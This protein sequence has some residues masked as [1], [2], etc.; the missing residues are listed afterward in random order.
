MLSCFV[1]RANVQMPILLPLRKGELSEWL[2]NQDAAIRQWVKIVKFSAK[3]GEVQ[4]IPASGEKAGLALVGLGDGEDVLAFGAAVS[5]L[6]EGEYRLHPDIAHPEPYLL[7]FGMGAYRFDQYKSK[8]KNLAKLAWPSMELEKQLTPLLESIYLARDMIN[9]PAEDMGPE[10]IAKQVV[11]IAKANQAKINII[12]GQDLLKKNY[13]SIHAVGRASS[14]PPLLID[15]RWGHSGPQIVLVGKGVCFDSG[16]LDIKG[17]S[18]MQMMKKDMGGAALM[19]ALAQAIMKRKLKLRL[20]LLIPAVDNAISGNA[21][22]PLDVFKT[23][24]GITIEIGNTDAEGRVILCDALH[25]AASEKPDLIID[26]AT[27][28]GAARVAL[29]TELPAL[30]ANNEA[31][32]TAILKHGERQ[33]DPLWPLPLYKPYRRLIESKVADITNNPESSYGGAITAALFLQEFVPSEI[34]WVHIDTM[35]W[36]LSSQPGRPQGGEA[37]GLRALLS[38]IEDLVAEK[39]IR[40]GKPAPRKQLPRKPIRRR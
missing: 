5:G 3:V 10:D 8:K 6:P 21:Y 27:L 14:R 20:R 7:A 39:K 29:G 13:P 19:I 36:N 40:A 12:K 26:A 30:F 34:P 38:Y 35:A 25:E 2:K 4:F 37:F 15:L 9:I 11:N 32:A 31:V 16:G 28:T 22:R 18:N 33:S 23:R 1:S 17:A 24:K